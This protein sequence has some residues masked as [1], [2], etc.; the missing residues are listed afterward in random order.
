[1]SFG[2]GSSVPAGGNAL[3]ELGPELRD[4]VTEVR[5]SSGALTKLVANKR[6]R[7]SASRDSLATQTS[8]YSHRHGPTLRFP[9]RPPAF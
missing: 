2:F 4:V 9:P 6:Y 8:A 3:A 5:H 1:M 7:N